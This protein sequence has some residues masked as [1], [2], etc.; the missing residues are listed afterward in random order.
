MEA[1]SSLHT[2]PS[3]MTISTATSHPSMACGPPSALMSSGIVMNGP[4]PI[5]FD[6]LRA[7]AWSRP[8][9]RVR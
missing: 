7:V 2:I 6:M 5:M 4:T 9:R 8:K 1:P 3:G